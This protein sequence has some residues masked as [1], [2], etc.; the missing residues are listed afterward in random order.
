VDAARPSGSRRRWRLPVA[1]GASA[2]AFALLAWMVQ[3]GWGLAGWDDDVLSFVIRH[4]AGWLTTFFRTATWLGSVVPLI[5]VV[6]L[7]SGWFV[8]RWRGRAV[9]A[10]V[11]LLATYL[12]ASQSKNALKALFDRSRPS[13]A[14]QVVSSSGWAFPSGHAAD[15]FAVWILLAALVAPTVSHRAATAVWVG[16]VAIVVVVGASRVYLGVHWPTDVLAGFALS[17]FW[18]ALALALAERLPA[19]LR[20]R[21]GPART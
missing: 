10:V 11:T 20:P 19:G 17:G 7:A 12:A 2:G 15:A 5:A 9:P 13:Q 14:V 1:A 6:V 16:A 3:A 21:A 18:V 8:W 4:R